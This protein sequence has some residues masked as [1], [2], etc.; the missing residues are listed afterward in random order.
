MGTSAF[1]MAELIDPN[2][3]DI[4]VGAALPA[5]LFYASIVISIELYTRKVGV[6]GNRI[7]I[8]EAEGSIGRRVLDVFSHYEYLG[9]AIMLVYW[10]IYV[11]ADPMLSAYY[12][13]ITLV[14]LRVVRTIQ[15][16][17]SGDDMAGAGT[18]FLRES[19][20]GFRRSAESILNITIMVA[21]LGIIVRAFIVTGFA[22]N[23]STQLVLLSGGDVVLMVLMAAIASIVFGMGMPTVAAY[24][25]VAL[26]VAPPLSD[27]L[28][29]N[30]LQ[31]HM[32][33]FY[34]AILSNI[35]PPIA[36]AV[37][38]AQGIAGSSFLETA[39]DALRMG[40]PMF[41]LPFLFVFS[42]AI[43][44]VESMSLVF[45]AVV[46]VGFLALSVGLI[47]YDEVTPLVRVGF[48][49]AVLGAVFAPWL[50]LQAAFGA[51]ILFSLIYLHPEISGHLRRRAG[52][53]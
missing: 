47:G 18:T 51:L 26:F 35:T 44:L 49:A 53:E 46:A 50:T 19:L 48:L 14:G 11:Q 4:I 30:Q 7:A 21:A 17:I 3:T 38:V 32:F 29:A 28:A 34:F 20:E 6:R 23:L 33:V 10:L 8:D 12:S 36:V 31:V 43:L 15:N 45:A 37:V 16:G 1:I 39:V 9:M 5:F 22:Q 2:Y 25:L 52:L 41:L 40:F 13:I 27:V 24:L 42:P